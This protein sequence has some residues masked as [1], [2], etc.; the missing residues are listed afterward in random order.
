MGSAYGA[1]ANKV[2]ARIANGAGTFLHDVVSVGQ[3]ASPTELDF[4]ISYDG[5]TLRFYFDGTLDS[6]SPTRSSEDA[7]GVYDTFS[8]GSLDNGNYAVSGS[9]KAL[10]VWAGAA[11]TPTQIAGMYAGDYA[12]IPTPNH[13]FNFCQESG[14]IVRDVVGRQMT[15]GFTGAFAKYQEYPPDACTDCMSSMGF[16]TDRC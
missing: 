3:W 6:S 14:S 11:L 5:H 12:D 13:H 1:N 15:L 2:F 4:V 8:F 16:D 10:T 7:L 9:L